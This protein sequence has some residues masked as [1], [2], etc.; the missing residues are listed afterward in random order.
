M[1]K[2]YGCG[3]LITEN[4]F[5]SLKDPSSYDMR[6][7]ARVVV[8]GKTEPVTV[9]EVFE[10]DLE[11]DREGKIESI[12]IF[13]EGISLYYMQEFEDALLHF[14][15]CIEHYPDDAAA[16]AYI[17]QCRHYINIGWQEGW[18]GVERLTSK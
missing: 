2:K 6:I 9:W 4:T 8:K 13:E 18:D 17:Q 14:Q 11:K 3:L 12:K 16:Q 5:L 1:T 7:M 15:Q 10:G